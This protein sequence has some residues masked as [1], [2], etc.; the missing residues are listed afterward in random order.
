MSV[1]EDS[2]ARAG[3]PHAHLQLPY[4]WMCARVC[5]HASSP[6]SNPTQP[7]QVLPAS[8]SIPVLAHPSIPVLTHGHP[9]PSHTEAATLLACTPTRTNTSQP[10]H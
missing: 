6:V 10:Q 4:V 7:G 1:R 3:T 5:V 9:P 2:R 8:P